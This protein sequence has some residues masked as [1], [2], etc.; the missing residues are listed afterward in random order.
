VHRYG[1]A[2]IPLVVTYHPAYLL[3]S[4]LEKRKSWDD[5]RLAQQVYREVMSAGSPGQLPDK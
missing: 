2:G 3:R 4:P 1:D 5:L